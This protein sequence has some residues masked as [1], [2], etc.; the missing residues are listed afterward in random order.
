MGCSTCDRKIR[1]GSDFRKGSGSDLLQALSGDGKMFAACL[2]YTQGL[3]REEHC[4]QSETLHR[5]DQKT[6]RHGRRHR[7]RHRCS[8]ETVNW[9][10]RMDIPN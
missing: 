5:A 1:E 6:R 7:R 2:L 8:P 3:G 4:I 10:I 9:S